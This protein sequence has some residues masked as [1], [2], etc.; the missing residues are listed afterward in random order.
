MEQIHHVS[1]MSKLS[2]LKYKKKLII[3][4]FFTEYLTHKI[5][6]VL[7]VNLHGCLSNDN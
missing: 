3:A 6:G 4:E 7:P 2:E 5:D 1:D